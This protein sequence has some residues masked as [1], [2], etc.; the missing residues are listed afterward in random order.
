MDRDKVLKDLEIIRSTIET[1]GRYSNIPG[2]GYVTA[3]LFGL[4]GAII[5]WS[6]AGQTTDGL[7]SLEGALLYKL[8]CLWVA[9]FA[10]A[11]L[12]SVLFAWWRARQKGL[13]AWDSLTRRMVL[14]QL[15]LLAAGAV[16][17]IAL[18]WRGSFLLI[19]GWWLW[20][21]GLVLFFFHYFT[22]KDHL[23]QAIIFFVLGTAALFS[24]PPV[25]PVLLGAGFGGV[26]LVC[27]ARYL[28]KER[29]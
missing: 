15:P 11:L 17:T 21:Y 13:R 6:L 14:S 2:E 27:G 22:G 10:A 7:S 24:P 25:S 23:V 20:C 16:L 4:A 26:H 18:A 28:L 9:V 29:A 8:A 19:P 1:A 12:L 3:G 5:T